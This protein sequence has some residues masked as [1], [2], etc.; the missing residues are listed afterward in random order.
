MALAS[1]T[2]A[3]TRRPRILF[4]TG[5]PARYY[6]PKE[7][8]RMDLLAP[9]ETRTRCPYKGI[10]SYWSAR[11]GGQRVQDIAW[12]YEEPIPECP[13]IRG[14]ICFYPDRVD[15]LLVDGEETAAPR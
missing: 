15:S 3:E 9:S 5:L 2:L 8:V 6:I 4:E 10:A 12:S 13:K 11:A 7:D 1:E 14:L